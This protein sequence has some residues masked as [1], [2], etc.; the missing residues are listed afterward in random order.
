M[1]S[2]SFQ[3]ELH[4]SLE[5]LDAAQQRQV[6]AYA[7]SLQRTAMKGTPG[8]ALLKFA[9]SLAEADAAEVL[10]AIEE[11]CEKVDPHGW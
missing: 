6:L 7:K 8:A 3:R 1:I 5:S 10:Q 11:G 2:H 9:G 4:E